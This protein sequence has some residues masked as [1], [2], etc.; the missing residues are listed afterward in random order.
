MSENHTTT[1]SKHQKPKIFGINRDV[2]VFIYGSAAADDLWKL[3]IDLERGTKGSVG[4][5]IHGFQ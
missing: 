5:D 2:D 3:M 1:V 4:S